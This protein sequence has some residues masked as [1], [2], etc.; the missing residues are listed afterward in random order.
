MTA[1]ECGGPVEWSQI[2]ELSSLTVEG[3]D[4]DIVELCQQGLAEPLELTAEGFDLVGESPRFVIR[5]VES[6]PLVLGTHRSREASH[7]SLV[8]SA[9]V[10]R[11][12]AP[13]GPV[14]DAEW[15]PDL[16]VVV[17]SLPSQDDLARIQ[18]LLHSDMRVTWIVL[19]GRV[20]QGH[21]LV[22]QV[23]ETV[24]GIGLGEHCVTRLAWP[25]ADG[26]F[27]RKPRLPEAGAIASRFGAQHHVI[28]G[29]PD[30]RGASRLDRGGTVV[31]FTGL[32]GSG[33]STIARGLRENIEVISDRPVNLLDGD[34]LRRM[35]SA[36]LGFDEEGRAANVRRVSWVAALLA[37][38]GGIAI[39][40]LIAPHSAIR[41]EARQMAIKAGAD[42]LEVWVS[43]PLS[44]CERRD[45]KGLYAMARAGKIPNFTGIDSPYEAP[46]RADLIVDTSKESIER[47]VAILV[48]ELERR[49]VRRGTPALA[50]RPIQLADQ[51]PTYDI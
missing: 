51:G 35:L 29:D 6:T 30:A 1:P 3:E 16:A 48:E 43:T 4:L 24:Q 33:K 31:F 26:Q 8:V 41:D 12:V 38:N 18:T 28:V 36:G 11:A 5:D 44:E 25:G 19:A 9:Q 7:Q 27:L 46:A 40:A 50:R 37:G 32:S 17:K 21:Q 15:R 49:A 20:R 10:L 47:T 39:T 22:A 45:R 42:F 23:N 14:A 34:D 2:A 13:E